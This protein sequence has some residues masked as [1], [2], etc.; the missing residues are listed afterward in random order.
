MADI[1]EYAQRVAFYDE[2]IAGQIV[3]LETLADRLAEID[4]SV[5][6]T[7]LLWVHA[8]PEL[9]RK[10]GMERAEM[11]AAITPEQR[12][13]YYEVCAL[14]LRVKL[15]EKVMDATQAGL[16]GI[17]SIMKYSTPGRF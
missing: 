4:G 3:A 6:Q 5:K 9:A 7:T 13:D 12:A 16:S 17:Q 1:I 10:L 11:A 14:R 8:N 15:A 2:K